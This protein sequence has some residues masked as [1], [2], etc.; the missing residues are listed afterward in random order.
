MKKINLPD[1]RQGREDR[2]IDYKIRVNSYNFKSIETA[3][4]NM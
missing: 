2:I 3:K 1:C 4:S